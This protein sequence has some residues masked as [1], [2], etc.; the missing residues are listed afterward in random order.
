MQA[1]ADLTGQFLIAMPGLLG[2]PFERSV[3]FVCQY[4]QQG[5]L[6]MIINR[7]NDLCLGEVLE[8]TSI[9][10][11]NEEIANLAVYTGGPVNAGRCLIVHQPIGHWAAT[12]QVSD[13]MGVTGSSDIL[14]AIAAGNGPEKFLVCLGYAGWGPGQ[15]DQEMLDN[16]WLTGPASAEVMFDQPARGRWRAAADAVG[17]DL[18]RLSS[19]TG[20]G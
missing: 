18:D 20:H 5:A 13:Q 1:D 12:L 17:I 10:P 9:E 3:C 7:P 2:E 8:Q 4:D 14:E 11:L 19:D 16:S 6:G 15:L